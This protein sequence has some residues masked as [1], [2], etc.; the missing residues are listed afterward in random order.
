MTR[1][2]LLT[3]GCGYIG[4]VLTKALSE[5][6]YFVRVVDAQWFGNFHTNLSKN[7]QLLKKRVDEITAADL[8][9]V[10][11]VIHLANIANDP[12]VELNPTLSWEINTLHLTELLQKCK[13]ATVET[14]INASSGSVYGIKEQE[15]VTEDLELLPI[16]TYNKTKMVAER[17]CL[18]FSKDF[19]IV[20]VRP[21]TVCGLSP[22]MRFDVVVNMFVLQAFKNGRIEVLGG[23]QVR[24]NIHID[25]MVLV[26]LHL[27]N[28]GQDV[29]GSINAGFENISILEIA[30]LVSRHIPCEIVVK[31]SND[32]RSYRQDSTKLINSGF[33]PKKNVID[34]IE[35]ISEKLQSGL[36][37]DD[38][39]WHTV[40]MMK[41]LK[42]DKSLVAKAH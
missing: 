27:L 24:P 38:L 15:K 31:D 16:S 35:E 21:A 32:P 30:K 6:G 7:V 14:F 9:S 28:E 13:N 39:R 25:D 26:Y 12:G 22:R 18:S 36:L 17:I 3:G 19:R 23:N 4:S 42:L 33:L 5:R 1:N 34:A 41:K 8:D 29:I 20:N 37:V 11:T 40:A 10:D 2:I